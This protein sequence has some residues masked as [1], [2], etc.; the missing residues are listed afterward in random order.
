MTVSRKYADH[1]FFGKRCTDAN[2]LTT[3]LRTTMPDLRLKKYRLITTSYRSGDWH[4]SIQHIQ[5]ITAQY[6]PTW[7]SF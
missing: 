7:L 4:Q 5:K 6:K 1:F 2:L 3:D